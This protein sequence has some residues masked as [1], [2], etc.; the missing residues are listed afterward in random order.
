MCPVRRLSCSAGHLKQRGGAQVP[1]RPC[2]DFGPAQSDKQPSGAGDGR[3]SPPATPIELRLRGL[4]ATAVAPP[5]G[6]S[7][8]YSSAWQDPPGRW[9]SATSTPT[10]ARPSSRSMTITTRHLS[11]RSV[12]VLAFGL[13]FVFSA[14]RM[15]TRDRG[16]GSRVGPWH[17]AVPGPPPAGWLE[18]EVCPDEIEG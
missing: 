11:G 8:Q 2:R 5:T 12:R 1:R 15:T 9:S 13:A 7:G 16:G 4:P 6:L 18:D 10:T 17:M 3:G 14:S